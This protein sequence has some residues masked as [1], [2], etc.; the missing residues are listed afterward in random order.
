MQMLSRFGLFT[1][2]KLGY[3]LWAKG[4]WKGRAESISMILQYYIKVGI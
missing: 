4:K 2:M 1:L 3:G